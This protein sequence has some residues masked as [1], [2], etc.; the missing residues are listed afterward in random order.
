[1]AWS[2]L[3][4]QFCLEL[5]FGVLVTLA[6]VARAPLGTFFFRLMG[7]TALV[8]LLVAIALPLGA[9][10]SGWSDPRWFGAGL[11][12]AL[13]F[14]YSAPVR[15]RTRE[16]ALVV[17]A[18]ACAASLAIEVREAAGVQGGIAW[19]T[20]SLSALATGLVGGSVGLAMVFGHWYLTVP[21]LEVAWLV[22]LN[23]LTMLWMGLSLVALVATFAVF[24]DSM[25]QRDIDLLGMWPLFHVGTRVALGIALPLLFGWMTSQSLAYKNTRSATGILYA[26]TVLVLIGTAVSVFLQDIY[27]VPL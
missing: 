15:A 4:T 12:A 16:L 20:A 18:L 11:S 19:A 27:G 3:G 26:S 22:K 21:T 2:R 10:A 6:F 5:A 7:V 17:A 25:K 8:P 1:M 14:V 9:H 23:R 13:F 24:A